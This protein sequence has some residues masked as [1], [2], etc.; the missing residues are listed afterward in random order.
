ML[1]YVCMYVL[2]VSVVILE[3]FPFI[4]A[5][6]VKAHQPF[7]LPPSHLPRCHL[8]VLPFLFYSSL[9]CFWNRQHTCSSEFKRYERYREI[10]LSL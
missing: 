6:T 10:P 8:Y 7:Q 4:F 9:N 5:R 2:Y 1:L 3:I